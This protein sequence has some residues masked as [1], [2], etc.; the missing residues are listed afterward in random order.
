MKL[1]IDR[2]EALRGL[3][4][5]RATCQAILSKDCALVS[6]VYSCTPVPK[7]THF[8]YFLTKQVPWRNCCLQA[9]SHGSRWWCALQPLTFWFS[10]CNRFP[11]LFEIV[12][13]CLSVACNSVYAERS[14]SQYISQ[15]ASTPEFHRPKPSTLCY[16]MIS[17]GNPCCIINACTDKNV[18]FWCVNWCRDFTA[19]FV[20]FANVWLFRLQP[21][22]DP[23]SPPYLAWW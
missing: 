20:I 6:H 18:T 1:T 21:A 5:S 12:L 10:S 22:R 23:R 17:N 4:V 11:K 15:C 19:I 2:H 13:R 8:S 3:F 7:F 9:G 16:M 14:V